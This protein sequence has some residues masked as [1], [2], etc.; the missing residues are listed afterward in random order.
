MTSAIE[1]IA[2]GKS[3][4]TV[5]ADGLAYSS[6]HARALAAREDVTALVEIQALYFNALKVMEEIA[7]HFRDDTSARRFHAAAKGVHR[8]Y[9]KLMWDAYN[10]VPVDSYSEKGMDRTPR[11]MALLTVSL[12][13]PILV[14]RRWELLVDQLESALMTPLGLLAMPQDAPGSRQYFDGDTAEHAPKSGGIW[15]QFLGA[16]L[17]AH[18]KTFGTESS[19]HNER[20]F[21]YLKPLADQLCQGMLNHVPEFFDSGEPYRERGAPAD[22][23][24]SGQLIWAL[25][26]KVVPRYYEPDAQ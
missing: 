6:G 22:A 14:R 23:A 19:T 17:A 8:A 5:G 13:H 15:P 10:H 20:F 16:F 12:S 25:T 3:H 21:E 7:A 11:P 4:A 26:A 9:N 2:A 18:A 1:A 24:A